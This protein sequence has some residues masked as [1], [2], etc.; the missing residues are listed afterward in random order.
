LLEQ[1]FNRFHLDRGGVGLSSD[2]GIHVLPLQGLK[3]KSKIVY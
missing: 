3:L 2:K 1:L